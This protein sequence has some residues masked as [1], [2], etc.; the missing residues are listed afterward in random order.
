MDDRTQV[1]LIGR[2]RI[3]RVE[4]NVLPDAADDLP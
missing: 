2:A 3:Q 1:N 4:A